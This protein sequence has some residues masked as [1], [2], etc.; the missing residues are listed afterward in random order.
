MII[1]QYPIKTKIKLL[2]VFTGYQS[3]RTK[4]LTQ[5]WN[6][7]KSQ[8]AMKAFNKLQMVL[9]SGLQKKK[10]KNITTKKTKKKKLKI[11]YHKK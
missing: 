5:T 2:Y 11:R 9:T 6:K 8:Y 7:S 3:G 1:S 10:T 4:C